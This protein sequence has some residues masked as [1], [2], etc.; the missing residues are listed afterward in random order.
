MTQ[1]PICGMTVDETKALRGERD[2]KSYYFCSEHCQRKFLAAPEESTPPATSLA[3]SDHDHSRHP[4]HEVHHAN[5]AEP[6][7]PPQTAAKKT[8]YTCPMH[9]E[10][11]QDHPGNC[12]K[13]GMALRAENLFG[14]DG[15]G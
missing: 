3:Q 15:G 6:A 2:G 11:E 7:A 12:P 9:P 4:G 5:K 14:G 1:D 13:C 10:V 8:I